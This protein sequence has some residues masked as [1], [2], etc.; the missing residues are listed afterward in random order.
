[1]INKFMAIFILLAAYSPNAFCTYTEQRFDGIQKQTFDS[2][3]GIAS[4]SSILKDSYS[5]EKSEVELL[6][7]IKIKPEYSFTDISFLASKFNIHT[8]AVKISIDQLKEI[9]SPTILYIQRLGYG[10]FVILKGI[11]EGWIQIEDPAWGTLNYTH[12]QFE[13]YWLQKD[14]L[15]RALIFLKNKNLGVDNSRILSKTPLSWY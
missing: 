8:L 7:L 3:C 6:S 2:T 12:A 15:G 1:M 5:I 4:I 10:H 11:N 9:H 13:R 14:H